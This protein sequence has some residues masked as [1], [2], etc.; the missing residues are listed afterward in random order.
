MSKR[1][2]KEIVSW[3]IVFAVALGLA[4]FI[5]KVII[6]RVNIPSGSMEN[7][8]MTGDKVFT[9]RLAYLFSEPK[10]G[11]IIVFPFPDNEE[12]DYIKRIIGLPGEVIEGKDGIVF[13]NG[14]PLKESYVKEML[15]NDF[16]PYTVPED[17]Y[18][19]MGDNRN[20]SEDSRYW[21]DKF[22]KRSK[23]KGKAILKYPDL[24]W[25]P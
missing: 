13:I 14:E 24:K 12:D 6:F 2:I 11:D 10:R 25:L 18:F 16:G 5:N 21:D 20:I 17:S 15:D 3:V 1:V 22:V 23:I 19:M 7:T 9:F 8:I 4:L